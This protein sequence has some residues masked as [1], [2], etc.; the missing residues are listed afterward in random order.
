MLTHQLPAF[1]IET[2]NEAYIRKQTDRLKVFFS[3]NV[4]K[5]ESLKD[6]MKLEFERPNENRQQI[7]NEIDPNPQE[8]YPMPIN[9]L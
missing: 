1:A 3:W 7:V 4:I 6:P 5:I 8:K 2:W 9:L